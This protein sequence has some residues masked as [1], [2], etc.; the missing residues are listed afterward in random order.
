MTSVSLETILILYLSFDSSYIVSAS[1]FSATNNHARHSRLIK[2]IASFEQVCPECGVSISCS[3]FI[4][5]RRFLVSSLVTLKLVK[6][7]G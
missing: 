1:V 2:R 5:A 7:L 6:V 3:R 4:P